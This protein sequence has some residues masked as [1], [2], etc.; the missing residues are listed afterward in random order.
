MYQFVYMLCTISGP[1]HVW[2]SSFAL[3]NSSCLSFI[4]QKIQAQRMKYVEQ[5]HT[6]RTRQSFKLGIN[7]SKAVMC[8]LPS[9]SQ[10]RLPLPDNPLPLHMPSL[11]QDLVAVSPGSVDCC[12]KH[13][14]WQ[15][16]MLH[17]VCQQEEEQ[18]VN[19]WRIDIFMQ[20]LPREREEKNQGKK[21]FI[22]KPQLIRSLLAFWI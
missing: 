14:L 18:L 2:V 4:W 22:K 3:H 6:A 19:S 21:L 7:D 10:P 8:P 17:K 11:W 5:S 9:W 15:L 12:S 13:A 16:W 20:G 1:V